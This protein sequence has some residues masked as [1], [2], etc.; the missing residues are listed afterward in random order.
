MHARFQF[1]KSINKKIKK[2][3]FFFISYNCIFLKKK[4]KEN[5]TMLRSKGNYVCKYTFHLEK[6]S[7]INKFANANNCVQ[8]LFE[9]NFS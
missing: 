4:T 2:K 1:Y 7:K 9:K 3:F 5:W 8:R 6:K